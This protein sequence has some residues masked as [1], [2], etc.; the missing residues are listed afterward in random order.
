ML[1]PEKSLSE[2]V[3]RW[4]VVRLFCVLR[5]LSF[6]LWAGLAHIII[7]FH[8]C[9]GMAIVVVVHFESTVR[10]LG[11]RKVSLFQGLSA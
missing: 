1:I 4:F 7:S 8:V 6:D 10:P 11:P 2:H 3:C 5:S 9:E